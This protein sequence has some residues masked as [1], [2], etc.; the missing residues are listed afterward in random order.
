MPLE[1]TVYLNKTTYSFVQHKRYTDLMNMFTSASNEVVASSNR[2]YL[3]ANL[4]DLI[5]FIKSQY[6]AYSTRTTLIG[7][8]GT[9]FDCELLIVS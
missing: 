7:Q 8:I 9:L 3:I 6:E 1:D 4:Q 5:E 2:Y